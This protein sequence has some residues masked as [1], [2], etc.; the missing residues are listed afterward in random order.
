MF[1]PGAL[2][3]AATQVPLALLL[4]KVFRFLS[5]ETTPPYT[6]PYPLPFPALP[7]AVFL[8][9]P[10]LPYLTLLHSIFPYPTLSSLTLP[11]LPLHTL[12]CPV[13]PQSPILPSPPLPC[14]SLYCPALP[15]C[16]LPI[17]HTTRPHLNNSL[18][19]GID[20]GSDF[21]R[22]P[23]AAVGV[24]Q[25]DFGPEVFTG[26]RRLSDHFLARLPQAGNGCDCFFY[27]YYFTVKF[28]GFI[29]TLFHI[30]CLPPPR[31]CNQLELRFYGK[32]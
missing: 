24:L 12:P 2:D 6:L 23:H 11:Y 5:V 30:G 20:I 15:Y 3:V 29:I 31:S 19:T 25:V 17:P 13:L 28:F 14:A 21:P 26:G 18:F 4:W 22:E 10:T 7:S 9:L 1:S 8:T 27:Y 32:L 16:S